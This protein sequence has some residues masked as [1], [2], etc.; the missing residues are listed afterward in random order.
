MAMARSVK[1][2]R[3]RP[4]VVPAGRATTCMRV[5]AALARAVCGACLLSLAACGTLPGGKGWGEQATLLPG[6]HRLEAALVRAVTDPHTWVPA[7]GALVF[8]IDDLDENVSDWASDHTPLFGSQRSAYD[9]SD[10]LRGITGIGMAATLLATP[11]GEDAEAMLTN[12]ARG[13]LVEIAGIVLTQ[14]ATGSI[15]RATDRERPNRV[16]SRSFPSGHSSNSAA[17][18]ALAR[19]NVDHLHLSDAWK[20]G[21]K[22]G[23]TAASGLTAWARVEAKAHYPSDALAG[24]ALGNFISVFV[25]DAFLGLDE[26]APLLSVSPQP[27]GAM[28]RLHARY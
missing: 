5:R 10:F 13:A 17:Y 7:A 15:K 18:A 27:G 24:L 6:P 19:R 28:L 25:H 3:K 16:N 21:A 9:A 22:L 11:S 4:G 26:N 1:H 12:K 2:S 8:V 14:A 20:R 23:L